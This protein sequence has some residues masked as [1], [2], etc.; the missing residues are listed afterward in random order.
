MSS[1]ARYIPPEYSGGPSRCFQLLRG[2]IWPPWSQAKCVQT[3]PKYLHKCMTAPPF[4]MVDSACYDTQV[5]HRTTSVVGE[6]S[7]HACKRLRQQLWPL[8]LLP[9][10][11]VPNIPSTDFLGF[12]NHK[13]L[14]P[15]YLSL[16][17]LQ[18]SLHHHLACSFS[19]S[20]SL[21]GHT[22]NMVAGS[23]RSLL[24]D[25]MEKRIHIGKNANWL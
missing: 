14:S 7:R 1:K 5:I 18:H 8:C 21:T 2:A 22:I 17:Q 10:D 16:L 23:T 15:L 20:Y 6:I 25:Y 3:L 9:E 4:T 24:E 19:L 12:H 11:F 13:E